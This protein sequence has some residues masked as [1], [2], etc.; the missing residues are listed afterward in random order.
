MLAMLANYLTTEDHLLYFL[1]DWFTCQLLHLVEGTTRNT[2][3]KIYP[4][5]YPNTHNPE[6]FIVSSL[7]LVV[8]SLSD[9]NNLDSQQLH[10]LLQQKVSKQTWKLLKPLQHNPMTCMFSIFCKYMTCL[11]YMF[12]THWTYRSTAEKW[13]ILQEWFQSTFWYLIW[14]VVVSIGISCV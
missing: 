6:G 8:G 9:N 2:P 4:W 1:L 14:W 5:S 10:L 12:W 11:S 3:T 13:I 7:K